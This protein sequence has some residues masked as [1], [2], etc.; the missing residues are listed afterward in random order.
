MKNNIEIQNFD[1][2][3][4]PSKKS[5]IILYQKNNETNKRNEFEFTNEVLKDCSKDNIEN[6]E[7]DKC[8]KR[9]K[10]FIDFI[11]ISTFPKIVEF[12]S[13]RSSKIFSCGINVHLI[14]FCTKN[15]IFYLY[16]SSIIKKRGKFH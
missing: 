7:N 8:K 2:L 13:K 10:S 15:S 5:Y 3:I 6:A 1:H 11:T 4:D 9:V 12:N 14:L 16:L